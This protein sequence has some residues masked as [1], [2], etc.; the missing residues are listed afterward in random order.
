MYR[1]LAIDGGGIRGI[2]PAFLLS[3]LER[4]TGLRT[5]DMFDLMVG[6]STGAILAAGLCV[7]DD[8]GKRPRYTAKNLLQIYEKRG[9]EIFTRPAESSLSVVSW[10]QE[11]IHFLADALEETHDHAPLQEIL[12]KY[13]ADSLLSQSLKDIVVTSY[14]I[15]RRTTYFFKSSRAKTNKGRDHLLRDVLRAATAGP[16]YF[17]PAV[18]RSR[19]SNSIRRVL[20]DGGVFASN[21]AMCGYVE[22][23]TTFKQAADNI[24]LLSLGTGIATPSLRYRDAKDWGI[25]GWAPHLTGVM[26]DGNSDAVHYHLSHLLSDTEEGAATRYY[27]FDGELEDEY[28]DLDNASQKNIRGLKRAAKRILGENG[29]EFQQLVHVLNS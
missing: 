24:L 18:V 22:A 26:M 12:E 15:E 20:V 29:K 5:A 10:F 6:T 1:I 8:T 16:T 27:R 19:A 2:I 21:P 7:A 9:R 3:A 11:A 13:F 14:D 25:L 23:I 4:E 17:E 28:A